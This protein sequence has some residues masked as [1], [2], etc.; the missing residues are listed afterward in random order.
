MGHKQTPR[1]L[2]GEVQYETENDGT[3][4]SDIC[5]SP[6]EIT[7]EA[8]AAY[9]EALKEWLDN[10]NG[11]GFFFVGDPDYLNGTIVFD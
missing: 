2:H 7:E 3:I 11:T 5:F 8:K 4:H 6:G 1:H 10:S 9:V